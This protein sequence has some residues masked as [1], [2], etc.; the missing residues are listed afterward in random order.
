MG[1]ANPLHKRRGYCDSAIYA[2][3]RRMSRKLCQFATR[4]E[5]Y[6]LLNGKGAPPSRNGESCSKRCVEQAGGQAATW[7]PG[8]TGN[9]LTERW[10]I[11]AVDWLKIKTEYIN[12]AISL[13][14]L[15]KKHDVSY[16]QLAKVSAS[17]KWS[18]QRESQRIKIESE[19]NQKAADK[20]SDSE[21]E[22]AAVRS[23][24]KLKFYQQIEKRLAS[25]DDED[26]QEF[27]RLVQNYK[28]MCDIKDTD[29]DQDKESPLAELIRNWK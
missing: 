23:R 13:R 2:A 5:S 17:E 20:I 16:S 25:V 21:S 22:V 27:R 9:I 1:S 3:D 18:S 28:D 29:T 24:L 12:G 4:I 7:Q 11:V 19:T 8:E 6:E 26:G 10:V 15:A 14:N